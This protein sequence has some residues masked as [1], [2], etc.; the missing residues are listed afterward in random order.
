MADIKE[1]ERKSSKIRFRVLFSEKEMKEAYDKT[2]SSLSKDIRVPGF[3][4]GK[5]PKNLLKRYIG[6][7]KLKAEVIDNIFSNVY[8]KAKKDLDFTPVG[9]PE[10]TDLDIEENKDSFLEIEVDINPDIKLLN[11]SELEVKKLR[12][13]V[14]DQEVET[15]IEELRKSMATLEPIEEKEIEGKNEEVVYIKL[16]INAKDEEINNKY[17]DFF[18]KEEVPVYFK[19]EDLEGL[20]KEIVE[21]I[22]GR[23]IKDEIRFSY[24]FPED[25]HIE[26]LKGKEVD[27]KILIKEVKKL[28]IPEATDGFAKDLGYETFEE[29]K[30][31]IY[32]RLIKEKEERAEIKFE[33][34]IIEQ[35]LEKIDFLPPESY[36]EKRVE[37]FKKELLDELKSQGLTFEE[38]LKNRNITEESL[39]EDYKKEAI[40]QLKISMILDKIED[41]KKVKVEAEDLDKEIERFA[42][43]YRISK[44]KAKVLYEKDGEIKNYID[45][46]A[47]REKVMEILKNEVKVVEVEEESEEKDGKDK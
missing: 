37:T 31:D 28:V 8:T 17:K 10:I 27:V 4:K 14:T 15:S 24:R 5:A 13:K 11:F 6:E 33:N 36:I 32:D 34:E 2:L 43:L 41:E 1:V 16:D 40:R 45:Y 46:R 23:K 3:R 9:Y 12:P 35:I 38:Y 25:Y 18:H 19:T 47:R 30:K 22:K 44:E 39:E 29:L 7:E 20:D 21:S 26:D 42:E